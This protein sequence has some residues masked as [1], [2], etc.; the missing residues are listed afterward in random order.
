M[1]KRVV[2]HIGTFKTATT[3]MQHYMYDNRE[4]LLE[5]G[6][7]YPRVCSFRDTGHVV[8]PASLL[9]K[10]GRRV[11]FWLDVDREADYYWE[12]VAGE[13]AASDC[14]TAV[15]STEHFSNFGQDDCAASLAPLAREYLADF[16]VTVLCY[17]RRPDH[18]LLSWYNQVVKMGEA[19]VPFEEYY[20]RI[21]RNGGFQLFQ[22]RILDAWAEAVGMDG[23]SVHSFDAVRR[24][25]LDVVEHFLGEV[26]AGANVPPV[27][28]HPANTSIDFKLMTPQLLRNILMKSVKEGDD[29][30]DLPAFLRLYGEYLR[31]I[32]D[33]GLAE[34]DVAGDLEE[35]IGVI[36]SR[37]LPVFERVCADPKSSAKFR[38][39]CADILRGRQHHQANLLHTV[40]RSAGLNAAG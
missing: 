19:L 40:M 26:G 7:M 12:R 37:Y 22:S 30:V 31:G 24:E 29:V 1:R 27:S 38:K 25:G 20:R 35:E 28:S 14:H 13:I 39:K 10:C 9:R 36:S 17:L 23:M 4:A 33:D 15:L 3:A 5:R 21:L 16:D 11:P 6:V 18:Y 8:L 32:D 2:L 34:L